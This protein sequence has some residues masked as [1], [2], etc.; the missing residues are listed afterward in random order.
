MIRLFLVGGAV[1][2]LAGGNV[3]VNDKK[4]T[5]EISQVGSFKID[6]MIVGHAISKQ[7]VELWK[8]KSA[9]YKECGLCG[10]EP[11][12]FPAD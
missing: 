8:Q 6:P 11:Q 7:H 10:E 2:L 5:T 9:Q 4:N 12:A 1:L 3:L